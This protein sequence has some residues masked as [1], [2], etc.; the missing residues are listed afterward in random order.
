MRDPR[1]PA[2][3]CASRTESGARPAR[4]RRHREELVA[5]PRVAARAG[6]SYR[7][8]GGSRVR[9]GAR[10]RRAAPAVRAHAGPARKTARPA[11]RRAQRG[12]RPE[13]RRAAGSFPG[14]ARGAEPAGRSRGGYGPGLPRRRRAVAGSSLRADAGVRRPPSPRRADRVGVRGTRA[15]R[16]RRA[17]WAARARGRGSGRQRRPRAAGLGD[18]GSGRRAGT[19][20]DRRRD[21]RQPAGTDR[22]DKRL[23]PGRAGRWIR[24]PRRAPVDE[25][26][27]AELRPQAPVPAGRRATARAHRRSRAARRR[28]AAVARG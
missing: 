26:D 28:D 12:V 6:L 27:R 7:A 9:D 2:C 5:G 18:P 16:H 10:V 17:G 22:A 14:R 8:G 21:A 11:T 13:G 19:R 25:S 20:P 24:P 15:R 23:D 1:S 4:R 3:R